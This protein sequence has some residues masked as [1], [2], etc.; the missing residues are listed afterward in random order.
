M[1]QEEEIN[2]GFDRGVDFKSIKEKLINDLDRNYEN[3]QTEQD[4]YEK[5]CILNK[6]IYIMISLVQL[7]N[8]SRISESCNAMLKFMNTEDLTQKVHVKIAKS[9][10]MKYNNKTKKKKMSKARYR[11][12]MFPLDWINKDLFDD[13]KKQKPIALCVKDSL[14]R[15]RVRDY[16]LK[17]QNCNTHS[18]RYACIN[19]LI[20]DEKRPLNDVAKFVG[21]S[22][23]NQL[24]TYTQNINTDKIFDLNI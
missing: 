11:K 14:L 9:E 23:I 10:G 12:M 21:H 20:Y 5:Q 6:L 18:L 22:N 15:Q 24:V 17:N 16:L 4:L 3:L 19:Y 1:A 2:Q 13:I 7:R 8:G